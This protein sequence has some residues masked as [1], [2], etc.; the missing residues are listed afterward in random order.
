MATAPDRL[1][2]AAAARVLGITAQAVGMWAARP[3][4]PVHREGG[5]A[6]LIWPDFPRWRER[7][8]LAQVRAESK[9]KSR[10]DAEKR[11]A[12]AKAELAELELEE[13]RGTLARRSDV[14]AAVRGDY[15]RVR[16]RLLSLPAKAAPA[17]VGMKRAVDIQLALEGY[18]E[19]VVAELREA[20]A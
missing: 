7:E 20:V 10:D 11:L 13:K 14:E 3:G 17:L 12:A 4:A 5:R 15:E 18:V 2:Y 19:E 8:L 1:T 16:A 6:W 9:P